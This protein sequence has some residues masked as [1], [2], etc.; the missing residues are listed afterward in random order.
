MKPN[1]R[2]DSRVVSITDYAKGSST[3]MT[4]TITKPEDYRPQQLKCQKCGHKWSPRGNR[5]PE[6]C[7]NCHGVWHTPK[8]REAS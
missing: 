5:V 4:K 7:P 6:V 3:I 1:K 2:V 8:R